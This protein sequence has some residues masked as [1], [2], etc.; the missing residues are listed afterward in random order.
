MKNLT[1]SSSTYGKRLRR[2]AR[3]SRVLTALAFPVIGVAFPWY[4]ISAS[5]SHGEQMLLTA[6]CI[7]FGLYAVTYSFLA[8]AYGATVAAFTK[9]AEEE[10]V[11]TKFNIVEFIV[12]FCIPVA[13]SMYAFF[14]FKGLQ[15]RL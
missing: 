4:R 14:V 9:L 10:A 8:L 7:F 15:A 2:L 11:D 5:G 12:C 1:A 6:L 3:A 13:I